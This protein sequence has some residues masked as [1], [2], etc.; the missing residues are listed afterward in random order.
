MTE[1]AKYYP[2]K[3]KTK[4]RLVTR[5]LHIPLMSKNYY[6]STEVMHGNWMLQ[7]NG[8][9]QHPTLQENTNNLGNSHHHPIHSISQ[10]IIWEI[11]LGFIFHSFIIIFHHDSFHDGKFSKRR[12]F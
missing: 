3:K 1:S 8:H 4:S 12:I 9:G 2:V 5:P 7:R 11:D 10:I 6:A